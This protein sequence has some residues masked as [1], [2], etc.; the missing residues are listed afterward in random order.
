VIGSHVE[1]GSDVVSQETTMIP[2]EYREQSLKW[3]NLF[4]YRYKLCWNGSSLASDFGK[5]EWLLEGVYE[6]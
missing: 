5:Q 3:L 4:E 6:S 2:R 1:R